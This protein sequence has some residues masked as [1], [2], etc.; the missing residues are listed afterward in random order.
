VNFCACILIFLTDFGEIWHR[1]SA[2]NAVEQ[3]EFREN[4]CKEGRTFVIGAN[5]ITFIR[6]YRQTV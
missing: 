4:W 1:R 2:W 5:G 3:F 6:V